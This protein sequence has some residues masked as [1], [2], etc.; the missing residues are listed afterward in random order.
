MEYPLKLE[1]ARVME[2]S[3]TVAL[4]TRARSEPSWLQMII[5]KVYSETDHLYSFPSKNKNGGRRSL[6][7]FR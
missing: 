5:R 2:Y 4:L 1:R 6:N 3:S 7:E